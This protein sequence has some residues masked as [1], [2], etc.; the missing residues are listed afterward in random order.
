MTSPSDVRSA[1]GVAC[2]SDIV[3]PPAG[4]RWG[5]KYTDEAYNRR[6]IERVRAK[7]AVSE[8]GCWVWQ[9]ALT[10]NAY[11]QTAY[12]GD[13]IM[14]HRK[15]YEV[16]HGVKIDRWI[17]VCHSCDVKLCCN[18]DHL[19]LGT[20]QENSVDSAQKGRHQEGRRT[21]C[22]RGHEFSPE[23]TVV[24]KQAYREGMRRVCKACELI[25]SRLRAGW[26]LEQAMTLPTTSPG[27]RPVA[28]RKSA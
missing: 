1:D 27:H 6:W 25:R 5:W 18:P 28:G 15:M 16:Q 21:H 23:N 22:E 10:S 17:Y 14:V 7:C 19:W 8:R 9:G 3:R 12:R 24:R 11:G 26:T 2:S 20:P 4:Q 13:N